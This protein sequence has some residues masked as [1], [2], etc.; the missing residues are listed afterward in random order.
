LKKE[1][2]A[3]QKKKKEKKK[4]ETKA[5]SKEKDSPLVSKKERVIT[6]GVHA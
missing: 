1:V 4:E 2:W 3:M 5:C 6:K